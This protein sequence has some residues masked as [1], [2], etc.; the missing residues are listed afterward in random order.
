MPRNHLWNESWV[1][2]SRIHQYAT[3][4]REWSEDHCFGAAP[5]FVGWQEWEVDGEMSLI[6]N[7]AFGTADADAVDYTAADA[8][9]QQ[10]ENDLWWRE[11]EIQLFNDAIL[12][13]ALLSTCKFCLCNLM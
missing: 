8:L 11:R 13:A 9:Q 10:Q 3:G 6:P 12:E 1:L 7:D 4:D 2:T 5:S